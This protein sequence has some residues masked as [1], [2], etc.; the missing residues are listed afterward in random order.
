MYNFKNPCVTSFILVIAKL[1]EN[2]NCYLDLIYPIF[3][4]FLFGLGLL[5]KDILQTNIKKK[6]C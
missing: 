3:N 5:H 1:K 4:C 6:K 2:F